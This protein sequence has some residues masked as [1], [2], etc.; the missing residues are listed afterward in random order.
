[1]RLTRAIRLL[2]AALL[3]EL[4]TRM[5]I[6]ATELAEE[7]A[8]FEQAI[9]FGVVATVFCGIGSIVLVFFIFQ[10]LQEFV[11]PLWGS[12]FLILGLFAIGLT[13][14]WLMVNT[15]RGKP[16]ILDATLTKISE[17]I[18]ALTRRFRD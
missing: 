5:D 4:R 13:A 10:L 17:D 3:T 2:L 18:D 15:F 11:H 1:M 7:R 12:F 14:F 6:A 8:R 9:I 16:R